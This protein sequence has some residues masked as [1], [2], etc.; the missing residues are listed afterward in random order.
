MF[1]WRTR[2]T[3][4]VIRNIRR[5]ADNNPRA[6]QQSLRAEAEA[7]MVEMKKRTPVKTGA[8]K[9]SGRVEDFGPGEI[10]IKWVFG[11]PGIDYALPVHEDLEAFHP[12]GQAKY[13]ESVL[14]ESLRFIPTRV[15]TRM[16]GLLRT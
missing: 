10:G 2:G 15:A 8:L 6:A 11:G 1:E 14:N 12:V 7:E 9:G 3:E 5:L 4:R 16:R 13:M